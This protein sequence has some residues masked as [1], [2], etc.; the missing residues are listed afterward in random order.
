M[1]RTV[2]GLIAPAPEGTTILGVPVLGDDGVLPRLRAEGI[3]HAALG[4]GDNRLR[5]ALSG[6]LLALGF[7]LPPVLHPSAWISPSS[8]LAPGVVVLQHAALSADTTYGRAALI[9]SGAVVEHDSVV[10]EAAH[11]APRCAL[12]GH[13]R[14]G[15]RT[16][17]GIGSV[18]RP[19]IAI[20]ADVVVGAGSVV[21][22]DVPAGVTVM[23]NPARVRLRDR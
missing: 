3:A 7:N 17:V 9:N 11:V 4:I 6:R 1:G 20:G 12:A 10:E 23:G 18:L 5:D 2:T 15:A 19:G 16:L 8:S 22:R 13:T 14:V 21:V